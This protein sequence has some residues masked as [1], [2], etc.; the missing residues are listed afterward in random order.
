MKRI[1]RTEAYEVSLDIKDDHFIDPPKLAQ[2]NAVIN[3]AL[4]EFCAD[5]NALHEQTKNFVPGETSANDFV[6]FAEREQAQLSDQEI[7]EDWQIP[8]MEA[9]AKAITNRG[10]DILEIGFGRGVSADIIQ[11]YPIESHTIIEC[12]T[13]VIEEYFNPWK[14]AY[15][16][17]EIRLV[18]GLWQDTIDELGSFDG[19]FFHTYPL[20]EDEYM[21]YVHASITFAEHFFCYASEHLKPG[22]AF[23]YFSN[24]I[25]SV[26]REH[27]HLLLKHFSSFNVSVLPLDLPENVKDTWWA[28]SIVVIKAT[29]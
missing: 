22:G 8:L 3:R 18:E 2:R 17:K 15:P 5:L 23:T 21:E 4:K 24:E 6:G 10:G 11:K 25:Q 16:D 28:D 20:N 13:S 14:A 29:K 19:I 12:N 27:Q 26:G 9:M 1:K 7:M